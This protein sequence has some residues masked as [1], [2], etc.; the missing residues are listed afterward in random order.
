MACS[1]CERGG[2]GADKDKCSSGGAVKKFKGT[3]CFSGTL[4]EK[5]KEKLKNE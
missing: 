4:M 5:Y 2:N 3:G 1:E